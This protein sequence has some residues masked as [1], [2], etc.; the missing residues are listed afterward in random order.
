Q[1]YIRNNTIPL[2]KELLY[3][4][5]RETNILN[6]TPINTLDPEINT[7]VLDH[8]DVRYVVVHKNFIGE[9]TDEIKL[10]DWLNIK[11]FVENKLLTEKYFEDE[12]LIA[13]RLKTDML[14][15]T[16]IITLGEGWGLSEYDDGQS[17][18]WVSNEAIAELKNTHN[19]SQLQFSFI[20]KSTNKSMRLLE[21]SID[22]QSLGTLLVDDHIR[23]YSLP[24]AGLYDVNKIAF[25][26]TDL[27]GNQLPEN[28]S[29]IAVSRLTV[30]ASK[31]NV[32]EIYSQLISANDTGRILQIP[33]HGYY[34]ESSRDR[35]IGLSEFVQYDE[36]TARHRLSLAPVFKE[37]HGDNEYRYKSLLAG[38]DVLEWGYYTR[39]MRQSIVQ[40]NTKTVVI[41]KD[42]LS[43]EQIE[44]IL[45]FIN[46]IIPSQK[47][48]ENESLIVLS[49]ES[50][51]NDHIVPTLG[52]DGTW[53]ILERFGEKE[54]IRKMN[55]D[56]MVNI[57]N[58]LESALS[59]T[60]VADIRTCQNKTR[61]LRTY[62][63]FLQSS[64]LIVDWE[65]FQT[66]RLPLELTPGENT[67]LFKIFNDHGTPLTGE[68]LTECPIWA[69]N[70]AFQ[71][72]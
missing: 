72:K 71:E 22:Q 16:A 2:L 63:N 54:Q 59:G 26:V 56:S 57:F 51:G 60:L 61:V 68:A 21:M 38:H 31:P 12:N 3:E 30:S 33:T 70:I 14:E 46:E 6:H 5:P 39:M 19:A 34:T 58:P 48:E 36:T 65:E 47:I 40:S 55:R 28:S 67:V 10:S 1:E 41:H 9:N 53:D 18:R 27:Y 29:G 13:Y 49:I 23:P 11:T 50:S 37:L 52:I 15:P 20:A 4:L 64:E 8:Y 62:T 24:V 44:N 45:G 17:W 25:R 7:A 66:V 35:I 43:T 69:S 42:L 32:E